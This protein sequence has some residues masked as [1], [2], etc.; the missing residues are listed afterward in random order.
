MFPAARDPNFQ[1][2]GGTG[3]DSGRILRFSL[4]PRSR[5]GFKNLG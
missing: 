4:G 2:R 3:V 1:A 5:P